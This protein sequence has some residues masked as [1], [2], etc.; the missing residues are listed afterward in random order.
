M[1]YYLLY[2][3]LMFYIE[4]NYVVYYI[5]MYLFIYT[6]IYTIYTVN[7]KHEI[8]VLQDSTRAEPEYCP[9][10]KNRSLVFLYYSAKLVMI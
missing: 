6:R 4:V 8:F 3:A 9:Q 10:Y 5:A 1:V 2:N 7:S